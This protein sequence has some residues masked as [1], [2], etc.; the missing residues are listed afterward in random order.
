MV[1]LGRGGIAVAQNAYSEAEEE[2]ESEEVLGVDS[3]SPEQIPR[4][5]PQGRFSGWQGILI[6][7]GVGIAIAATGMRLLSLP[8]VKQTTTSQQKQSQAPSMSVTVAPVQNTSVTRTIDVP[9]TVA[10]R[11]DLIPVLPQTTGLQIKQ[12]LVQEGDNV[13]TGQV[14]AVLDNSV[15]QAQ[16][17][18]AQAQLQS[19]QAVVGQRQAARA[20]AQATLAD[21]LRTLQRYQT[22]ANQG[23][24]SRQDLDIRAT[25][26]ATNREAV[27]VAEANITSAQ[28]DVRNNAAKVQQLRTQLAQTIV[29]AP[30][31]GVVAE[32]I[33]RIGDLT[34]PTQ[35]LF[36]IIRNGLLEVQA[37]VAATQL[38]QVRM[39]APA[40]IT[41]NTDS[42]VRLRGRV[43][44][45][46]PLINQETRQATVK[47]DLPQ[48]SLL[49][50]GLFVRAAITTNSAIALTVP[51]QSVV[52]P[53]T[54]GSKVVFLVSSD[55]KVHA[56]PV[57]VGEIV[58]GERV[59]IAQGLKLGDRVV[60]A[61]AGYLNDGDRVQVVSGPGSS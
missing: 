30:V 9:G 8:S 14:M 32:K 55:G 41:S 10:A 18:Q 34:S 28:A 2:F 56:Q 47:I 52:F 61:G 22:L 45:I 53:A 6:G 23:A 59:E 48:N 15:L 44:E 46:A 1:V 5:S 35:R 12:V 7:T 43:R 36:S 60:V 38:G 25:T 58:N 42:R 21:A 29:R 4:K 51:A 57:Q 17:D 37:Q 3:V 33:A 16:L 27:R 24:I 20:Q 11:D 13:Q 50:P 54:G 26:A 39:N 19:A 49:R 40:Q 31:N